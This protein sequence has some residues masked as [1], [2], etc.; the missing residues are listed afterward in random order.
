VVRSLLR[1]ATYTVVAVPQDFDPE[2]L[3]FLEHGSKR[4][5]VYQGE[6]NERGGLL[7]VR[8]PFLFI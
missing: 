6:R 4:E 7:L 1:G 8:K 5:V 3:V 2:L